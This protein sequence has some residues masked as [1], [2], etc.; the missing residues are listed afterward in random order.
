MKKKIKIKRVKE[1]KRIRKVKMKKKSKKKRMLSQSLIRVN[2]LIFLY[3]NQFLNLIMKFLMKKKN[4]KS[5]SLKLLLL[6]T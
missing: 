3:K 5:I 1:R 6:V 4:L 2:L